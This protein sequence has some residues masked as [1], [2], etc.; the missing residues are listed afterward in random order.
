MPKT[1][2]AVGIP[3]FLEVTV[4]GVFSLPK[5]QTDQHLMQSSVQVASS[6]TNRCVKT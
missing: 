2:L 5:G 1:A 3:G 4:A 6:E